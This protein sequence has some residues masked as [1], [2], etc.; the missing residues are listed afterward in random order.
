MID[1]WVQMGCAAIG[2]LMALY[3]WRTGA[4]IHAVLAPICFGVGIGLYNAW[5]L[6]SGDPWWVIY[7]PYLQGLKD[8]DKIQYSIYLIGIDT[9]ALIY[10]G[11]FV[12][13]LINPPLKNDLIAIILWAILL[14]SDGYALL[15]ENLLCNVIVGDRGGASEYICGRIFGPDFTSLPLVLITVAFAWLALKWKHPK[16][17]TPSKP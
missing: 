4:S 15:F 7:E 6:F 3:L 9:R 16:I 17:R 2:F 10:C 13:C 8:S 1:F 12:F 11:L 5:I 14:L